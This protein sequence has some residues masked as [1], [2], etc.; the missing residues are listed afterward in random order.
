V[1]PFP[2]PIRVLVPR[3]GTRQEGFEPPTHSSEGCCSIQL[4]YWRLL[5]LVARTN[6]M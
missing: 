1:L 3:S 2:Y 6:E 4:S 5:L